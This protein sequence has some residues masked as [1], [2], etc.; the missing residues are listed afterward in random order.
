M[1]A[2]ILIFSFFLRL[3]GAFYGLPYAFGVDE[4]YVM[5]PVLYQFFTR[6][7]FDPHWYGQPSSFEMYTVAAVVAV[8]LAGSA[9]CLLFMGKIS[10][11]AGFVQ[12][13]RHDDNLQEFLFGAS[14]GAGRILMI[15]FS[16][17]TIYAV[18]EIAKSMAGK[19]AGW[20]AA[21]ALSLSPLFC[22][23]SRIIRPDIPS[24]FLITLSTLFLMKS[25]RGVFSKRMLAISALFAGFSMSAKWTSGISLLPVMGVALAFDLIDPPNSLKKL[26][27]SS[28][29]LALFCYVL[30]FFIFAPFAILRFPDAFAG[31][32]LE[33]LRS[34][35]NAE[36]GPYLENLW[37]NVRHGL[38][39]GFGG[40]FFFIFACIGFIRTIRD[41]RRDIRIMALFP[42]FYLLILSDA[43]FR[44][45][46]WMIP[47]LPFEAVFTAYGVMTAV[48]ILRERC[49]PSL[50]RFWNL[51][52]VAALSMNLVGTAI[53]RIKIAD[54]LSRGGPNIA[55]KVWIE[56]NLPPGSGVAYE[57]Y[58]PPLKARPRADLRL[59]DREWKKVISWPVSKYRKEGV[60]YLVL[61]T[62]FEDEFYHH[63]DRS[64]WQIRR[65]EEIKREA[66][67]V[68]SFPEIG[69]TKPAIE[70]YRIHPRPLH[71]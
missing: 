19:K 49:S 39:R 60:E 25:L 14:V 43:E 11:L 42:V 33:T 55:A 58:G 48:G 1:L 3:Y 12:L 56:A 51:L 10:G 21:I 59:Y 52:L 66:D 70:I 5:N 27:F 36:S 46:H 50:A 54:E 53:E 44:W 34:H 47:V 16:V 6:F 38:I 30:G 57:F 8:L 71:A 40:P 2:V 69:S 64:A 20:I 18:Y 17:L 35:M 45:D 67:M 22:D 32:M 9:L 24:A 7:D 4:E 31:L 28:S 41:S 62:Y 63:P 29:A 68:Q 61:E 15:V 37:W 65:Y 26:T 13:V 23:H